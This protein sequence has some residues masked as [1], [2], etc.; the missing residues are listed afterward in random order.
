MG[1]PGSGE[2]SRRK[3]KLTVEECLSLAIWDF[4]G[5]I[6]PKAAGIVTWSRGGD[7]HSSVQYIV[8]RGDIGATII[9]RYL[10]RGERKFT[11]VSLLET[12]AQFSGKRFWFACPLKKEG[13]VCKRRCG[14]LYLPPSAQEFGCRKCHDLTYESCQKSHQLERFLKQSDRICQPVGNSRTGVKESFA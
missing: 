14:K 4:K 3:R 10:R 5:V 1:G 8:V 9:L 2:W 6:Q 11:P 12:P 13:K 7:C